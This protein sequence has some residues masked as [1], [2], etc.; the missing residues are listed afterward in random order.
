M[1]AGMVQ[2]LAV[3]SMMT[4]ATV[5]EGA[6]FILLGALLAALIEV[7]V[8]NERLLLLVPRHGALQSLAGL[9]AGLVMP[10]CECGVVPIVHRLMRKGMPPRMA[11]TYMLAAPAMNPLALVSTYVAFQGNL[12]MVLGRAGLTM[13]CATVVGLVLSLMPRRELLR[14]ETAAV[15]PFI[16]APAAAHN[17]SA[18]GCAHC[19]SPLHRSRF[20][21]VLTRTAAE[22]LEMGKFL[23]LGSLAAAIFRV[24]LWAP[25]SPYLEGSP[26]ASVGVMM[27]LAVVLSVCSEADSFVAASFWSFGAVAQLAFIAIGPMVDIKLAVAYG[28][29]FRARAAALLLTLPTVMVYAWCVALMQVL[30]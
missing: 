25:V 1:N 24:F 27:F 15:S 10:T 4:T 12:W 11:L 3:T 8:S 29:L 7:F 28:S 19:H 23:I 14:A 22:F 2:A 30:E 17:P 6:P 26:S 20:A 18:C 16:M 13:T 21:A 9:G 5:V